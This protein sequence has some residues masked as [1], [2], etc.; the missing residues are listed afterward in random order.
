MFP[1]GIGKGLVTVCG[2][3]LHPMTPDMGQGG[4]SALEVIFKI[5]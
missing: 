5:I 1:R 2:D 3:A 4:C